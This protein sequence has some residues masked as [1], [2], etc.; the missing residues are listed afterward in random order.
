MDL[1]DSSAWGGSHQN[2]EVMLCRLNTS[3]LP[4]ASPAP[5]SRLTCYPSPSAEDGGSSSS[6]NLAEH[7]VAAGDVVLRNL[8][9]RRHSGEVVTDIVAR[10]HREDVLKVNKRS[11]GGVRRGG[12]GDN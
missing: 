4:P 12:R 6:T 8:V 7:G 2:I 3:L 1:R 5:T 11:L 10:L 9:D